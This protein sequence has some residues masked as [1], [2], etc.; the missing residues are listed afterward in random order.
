MLSWSL[1]LQPPAWPACSL[2]VLGN[3]GITIL[4]ILHHLQLQE[5]E[6]E[7]EREMVVVVVVRVMERMRAGWADWRWWGGA[8]CGSS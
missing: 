8:E 7:E 6:E 2:L 4:V 1:S 3:P 5:E